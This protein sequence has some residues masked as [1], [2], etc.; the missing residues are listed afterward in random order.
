LVNDCVTLDREIR[1]EEARLKELKAELIAEA[2]RRAP[3]HVAT[4]GGG[5]SWTAE[6][7]CGCVARVTFGAPT[8]KDKISGV[9]KTIEK[10]MQAAGNHFPR[11]FQQVPAWKP[12]ADFRWAANDL[13]GARDA[14]R[15][16]KLVTS[17]TAPRVSFET[18]KEEG[19]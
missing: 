12:V 15:L 10:V 4:E 18:K 14:K 3:E 2:V 13:L 17:E 19:Q 8:L 16:V 9:G 6:G 1:V 5:A 11:L 7:E